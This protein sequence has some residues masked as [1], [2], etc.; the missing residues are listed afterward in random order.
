MLQFCYQSAPF[1]QKQIAKRYIDAFL[2]IREAIS[3]KGA[4]I[5]NSEKKQI[6]DV[7][8]KNALKS[9]GLQY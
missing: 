9:T 7:S 6:C 8:L 1:Y 5:H 3:K 2:I 4:K